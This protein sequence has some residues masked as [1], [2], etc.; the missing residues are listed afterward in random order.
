MTGSGPEDGPGF[1]PII[2]GGW[3][4]SA[5][6]R[7]DPAPRGRTLETLVD[8]VETGFTAFDCADIYTGVEETFG[9]LRTAVRERLGPDAAAGLRFHTKLVPD[10]SDLD[11]VDRAYVERIVD[12]SLERLRTDRL[13][14]V[15][16]AWWDYDIPGYV[17]TALW[18][19]E[20]REAGKVRD[21]GVTNFDV[22]RLT[23]ILDAGVPVV[24]N[25]LQYSVLDRRPEHGMARLCRD[26]GIAML[27]YG[28][29]AGG[30]LSDRY[31]G[32]PDPQLDVENR[33]LTKYR[34]II[35]DFGG[36]DAYQA[37]LMALRT[38]A[39]EAAANVA[40]CAIAAVLAEP[41]VAAAIVGMSRPDRMREAAAAADV[42]LAEAHRQALRALAA[43]APGPTGDC[44]ELERVK[45]GRHAAVMKYDLNQ[46][47]TGSGVGP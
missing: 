20:L 15:Q 38:A 1:P 21:I 39:D 37:V 23:E 36:W 42:R 9:A 28:S 46:E 45:G 11:R 22:P 8:L 27:C 17:E 5:G 26:R 2:V 34:L 13:D 47:S 10:R 12:R 35:D 30:F 14:L 32:A 3:Q 19:D 40:Q 4:L 6:H 16:F 24:A 18:L 25:Q 44:F 29:L 43:A 41:G 33:S 7:R 31:L